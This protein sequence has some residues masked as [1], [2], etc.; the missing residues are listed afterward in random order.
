MA[1]I[2]GAIVSLL[3]N[4]E[5]FAPNFVPWA[6]AVEALSTSVILTM[7]Q[8]LVAGQNLIPIQQ[9]CGN[10]SAATNTTGVTVQKATLKVMPPPTAVTKGTTANL[11]VQAVDTQTN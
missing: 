1:V 2:P 3:V 6:P 7:S 9:M 11:V 8:P 10:F 4:G 5:N